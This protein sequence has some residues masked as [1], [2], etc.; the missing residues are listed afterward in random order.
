M[1]VRR[2]LRSSGGVPTTTG[3]AEAF[4]TRITGPTPQ[5]WPPENAERERTTGPLPRSRMP[6]THARGSG[7]GGSPA[8]AL[9]AI[10]EIRDPAGG[11]MPPSRLP[12]TKPRTCRLFAAARGFVMSR[13]LRGAETDDDAAQQRRRRRAAGPA[14]VRRRERPERA[15]LRRRFTLNGRVSDQF[16]NTAQS[17][18]VSADGKDGR[19]KV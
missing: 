2:G 14:L 16:Q 11:A 15:A 7:R 4:S 17:Q 6:S 10:P 18:E 3:I 12:R 9:T 8:Q 13:A 1:S 19:R 5:P